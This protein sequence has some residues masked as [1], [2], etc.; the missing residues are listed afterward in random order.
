MKKDN[1]KQRKGDKPHIAYI[2]KHTRFYSTSHQ[3]SLPIVLLTH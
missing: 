2:E 1:V 3:V